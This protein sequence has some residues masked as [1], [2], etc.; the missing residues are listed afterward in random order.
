MRRFPRFLAVVGS[1]LVLFALPAA[2]LGDTPLDV[3]NGDFAEGGDPLPGWTQIGTSDARQADDPADPGSGNKVLQFGNYN[4]TTQYCQAVSITLAGWEL[5]EVSVRVYPDDLPPSGLK[6]TLT[7]SDVCS[8]GNSWGD[9]VILD[10]QEMPLTQDAWNTVTYTI[11]AP[12]D[13]PDYLALLLYSDDGG[14]YYDDVEAS[15]AG[16]PTS[17]QTQSVRAVGLSPWLLLVGVALL[18]VRRLIPR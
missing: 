17:V 13:P 15:A 6:A 5:I 4:V 9:H 16:T 7:D 1:V 3:E 2:V 10:T 18:F 11:Q 14:I 12:A 8:D